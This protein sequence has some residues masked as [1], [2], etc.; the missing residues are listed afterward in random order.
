MS[1]SEIIK[2]IRNLSVSGVIRGLGQRVMGY[3]RILIIFNIGKKGEFKERTFFLSQMSVF[4][5][6]KK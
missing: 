2:T 1:K 3:L 4:I 5:K 6:N